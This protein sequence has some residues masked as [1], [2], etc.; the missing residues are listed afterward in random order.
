MRNGFVSVIVSPAHDKSSQTCIDSFDCFCVDL[1]KV[2]PLLPRYLNTS[3]ARQEETERLSQGKALADG[4]DPILL[5]LRTL[6]GIGELTRPLESVKEEQ[7]LFLQELLRFFAL[8]EDQILSQTLNRVLDSCEMN[9]ESQGL[10]RDSGLLMGCTD[11]LTRCQEALRNAKSN[12]TFEAVWQSHRQGLSACFRKAVSIAKRR[13]FN[14]LQST[15]QKSPGRLVGSFFAACFDKT[16]TG[17]ELIP[18]FVEM[19]LVEMA[20]ATVSGENSQ[21]PLITSTFDGIKSLLVCSKERVAMLASLTISRFCGQYVSFSPSVD[22]DCDL[23]SVEKLVAYYRCDGCGLFPIKDKRYSVTDESRPF[24]LCS[25]CYRKAHL[26]ASA[27]GINPNDEVNFDGC[28]IGDGLML[29]CADVLQMKSVE[30]PNDETRADPKDAPGDR[31]TEFVQRQQLFD[32]F[33][34][35]LFAQVLDLLVSIE[36]SSYNHASFPHATWLAQLAVSI[37]HYSGNSARRIDRSKKV[38]VEL[39][40]GLVQALQKASQDEKG[41]GVPCRQCS[42]VVVERLRLIAKLVVFDEGAFFYLGGIDQGETVASSSRDVTCDVHGVAACKKKC[43]HGPAKNKEFFCCSK[44]AKSRCNFFLWTEEASLQD[45]SREKRHFNTEI[46][47]VVWRAFTDAPNTLVAIVECIVQHIR[48]LLRQ[49]PL[50]MAE[51]DALLTENCLFSNVPNEHNDGFLSHRSR[52]R[53]EDRSIITL[54]SFCHEKCSDH[55][56]LTKSISSSSSVTV[57]KIALSVLSLIASGVSHTEEVLS[58]MDILCELIISLPGNTAVHEIAKRSLAHLCSSKKSFYVTI[59]AHHTF[60]YGRDKLLAVLA[61]LFRQGVIIREK[62]RQCGPFWKSGQ[63]QNLTD[64]K[65]G[66]FIGTEDL[67]SEDARPSRLIEE[68]NR[69]LGD[70]L[71]VA[72]KRSGEWRKFC[73]HLLVS[74]ALTSVIDEEYSPGLSIPPLS[75]LFMAGCVLDGE[76][77]V[78]AFRLVEMALD[79][80]VGEESTQLAETSK[81]HDTAFERLLPSST[82][83]KILNLSVDQLFSFTIRFGCYGESHL[84]RLLACSIISTYC[85]QSDAHVARELFSRLILMPIKGSGV[86]GR[87]LSEL[88]SS[89]HRIG[90]LACNRQYFPDASRALELCWRNQLYSICFNRANKCFV[91][92]ETR[93]MSSVMRKRYDFFPCVYCQRMRQ[94]RKD[95]AKTVSSASAGSSQPE[96]SPS[97]PGLHHE[98][99]L[100]WLPQQVTP[101]SRGRIEGW[102]QDFASDTHDAYSALKYRL[103]LS[104]VH[105]EVN[106]PR[107]RFVKEITI[108]TAPRPVREANELKGEAFRSK[109]ER[110]GQISLPKGATRGS[111]KLNKPVV[112]AN[113]RFEYSEFYERAGGKPDDGSFVVHCPRCS[114]VVTN[115]HGVC[116][117]CGEV[118]FQCRKCRHINYDRLD[119]FLCVEC[120]YCAAGTF[121]YEVTAAVASNAIAVTNDVDYERTCNMFAVAVRLYEDLRSALR[122]KLSALLDKDTGPESAILKRAFVGGLP[123]QCNDPEEETIVSLSKLGKKGSAVRAIARPHVRVLS[124]SRAHSL[125][126]LG[127][128][129]RE[130][131]SSRLTRRSGSD[132][133]IHQ[134]AEEDDD[135]AELFGLL[136]GTATSRGPDDPLARLLTSVQNRNRERRAANGGTAISDRPTGGDGLGGNECAKSRPQISKESLD[137][138]DRLYS[139][140]REA[141]REAFCLEARI[142]AWKRLESGSLLLSPPTA[143]SERTD[144]DPLSFQPSHCSACAGSNAVQLMSLWGSLLDVDPDKVEVTRRTIQVLLKENFPQGHRVVL[145]AK[146]NLVKD[147]ALKSKEGSQIV[148]EEL[149]KRLRA[150][151]SVVCAEILGKIIEEGGSKEF[152]QL[153]LEVLDASEVP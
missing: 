13:P 87:C 69:T 153:A 129:W 47:S 84:S 135:S 45:P 33:M 62:A 36:E 80:P 16:S 63:C 65:A 148:L 115:A 108:Y 124:N 4:N 15:G 99:T 134:L 88:L 92:F 61:P 91:S 23:F 53:Y 72:K 82:P 14:Y 41:D 78:R 119:A 39:I 57:I 140:M 55:L 97:Q 86:L 138:C 137:V 89:L 46:A 35:G 6:A 50:R 51:K 74:K 131:T 31:G 103:V 10:F 28:T 81:S 101:C 98:T 110:C 77:S 121:I 136:E 100:S 21:S 142:D 149:E 152:F 102:R 76:S 79:Y 7:R 122:D 38:C 112:A 147:I 85:T 70:L 48:H 20:A 25:E 127:R 17:M 66:D 95:K 12:L 132:I 123:L 26:Y 24:D 90:R 8:D 111:C 58:L 125:A 126:R 145:D 128:D 64:L 5:R 94:S 18:E 117:N 68:A 37:V 144:S 49:G 71:T 139:L 22:L 19:C 118:A 56:K 116:G 60:V 30:I 42:V 150:S 113:L 52:L 75:F 73:S 40:R 29:L 59:R 9:E 11:F 67:I 43:L 34:D 114:R 146:Y 133:I 109:W 104:E 151:E 120:G 83:V 44:D 54:A 93:N 141:E 106:D 105:L 1:S 2:L 96:S 130:A 3:V 32:D 107:G 143:S 27:G